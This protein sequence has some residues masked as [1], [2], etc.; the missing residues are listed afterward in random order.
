LTYAVE[1]PLP[2]GSSP[3]H[4]PT[5]NSVLIYFDPR[6]HDSQVIFG[7]ECRY[8]VGVDRPNPTPTETRRFLFCRPGLDGPTLK[9]L[10]KTRW[11]ERKRLTWT[12]LP[13]RVRPIDLHLSVA[14]LL[15]PTPMP[16]SR[17]RR[18]RCR[19]IPHAIAILLKSSSCSTLVSSSR[20]D[21]IRLLF[22]SR[23]R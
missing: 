10:E 22:R 15:T 19:P 7:I 2:I 18:R 4:Y 9:F 12:R 23:R 3:R 8:S 14:R 1:P 16:T 11:A 6:N 13:S 21:Y 17:H 20:S 5:L